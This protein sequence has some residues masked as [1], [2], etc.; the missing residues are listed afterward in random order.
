M[1]PS[2]RRPAASRG[3]AGSGT[4]AVGAGGAGGERG[5][6]GAALRLKAAG[7]GFGETALLLGP[8]SHTHTHPNW[9]SL[10]RSEYC[11]ITTDLLDLF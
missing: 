11:D 5:G 2:G 9:T 8:T 10:T 1:A 3:R 4:G 7:G 6:R